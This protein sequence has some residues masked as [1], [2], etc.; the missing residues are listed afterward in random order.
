MVEGQAA[1]VGGAE[2]EV[3]AGDEGPSGLGARGASS[4]APTKNTEGEG[5]YKLTLLSIEVQ[6]QSRRPNKGMPALTP[7]PQFDA[8]DAVCYV[9]QVD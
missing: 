5:N 9:I 3:G 7:D 6:C 8:I 1:R 4:C 2:G